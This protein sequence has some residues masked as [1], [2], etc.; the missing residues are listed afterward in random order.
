MQGFLIGKLRIFAS[1]YVP[2]I[3]NLCFDDL[4]IET[5]VNKL[6][7]ITDL[8]TIKDPYFLSL[9]N[10]ISL[11]QVYYAENNRL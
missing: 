11:L 4:N 9:L 3:S 8:E 10:T 7:F 2:I 6:S 1:F 5:I